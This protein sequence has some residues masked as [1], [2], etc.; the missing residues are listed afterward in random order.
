LIYLHG[1]PKMQS[2]KEEGL[3]RYL[4]TKDNTIFPSFCKP[5]YMAGF[6]ADKLD[7]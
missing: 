2:A 3:P 6:D 7:V 5:K 1:K 4:L